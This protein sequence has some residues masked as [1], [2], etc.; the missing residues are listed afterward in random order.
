MKP[1]KNEF[2]Q[3]NLIYKFTCD[4]NEVYIGETKRLLHTRVLEH[5]TVKDSHIY[6]HI[7]TCEAY[8]QKFFEKHRVHSEYAK[9]ANLREFIFEHFEIIEKN[10]HNKKL[11]ETSEGILITLEQPEINKQFEHKSTKLLSTFYNYKKP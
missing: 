3:S 5:R 10:L 2:F 7:A 1:L 4:C 6:S 8:N 9:H 11:R